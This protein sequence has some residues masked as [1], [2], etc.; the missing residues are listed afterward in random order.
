[1]RAQRQTVAYLM[2][3]DSAL[4]FGL[5][6][7]GQGKMVSKSGEF[8]PLYQGRSSHFVEGGNL[9]TRIEESVASG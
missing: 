7:W 5:V 9:T 2:G 1:M 8:T 3:D 4:G 6:I